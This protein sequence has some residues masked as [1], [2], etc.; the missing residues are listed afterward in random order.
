MSN[1]CLQ[2]WPVQ[3]K[4]IDPNHQSFDSSTLLIA[5]DCCAYAYKDFHEKFMKDKITIIG[6]PKLDDIDYSN[7]LT[8]IISNNDIKKVAVVRMEVPCCMGI[9]DAIKRAISNSEKDIELE[10]YVISLG[11]DIIA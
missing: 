8:E 7:K 6:C 11:G 3:I 4:L 5:A 9:E 1:S 2:Q 10:S